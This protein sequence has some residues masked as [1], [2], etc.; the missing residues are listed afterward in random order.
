MGVIAIRLDDKTELK[1]KVAAKEAGYKSISAYCRDILT[2]N[3]PEQ[4]L[5]TVTIEDKLD[6]VN[7]AQ[8]NVAEGLE[9]LLKKYQHDN[10]FF[11]LLLYSFMQH[12]ADDNTAKLAWEQALKEMEK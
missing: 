2:N 3:H 11:S 7:R 1:I 8:N 4:E 10:K 12:A 9:I 5:N 6:R